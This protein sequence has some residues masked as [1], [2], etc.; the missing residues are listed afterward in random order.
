MA[1]AMAD[2]EDAPSPRARRQTLVR[3]ARALS[4]AFSFLHH[5]ALGH[6]AQRPEL[7]S[8]WPPRPPLV[9]RKSVAGPA[10][11]WNPP[12]ILAKMPA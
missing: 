2:S 12:Q 5:V 6:V 9:S 7:R 4:R 1:Q 11:V 3:T 8:T 10:G